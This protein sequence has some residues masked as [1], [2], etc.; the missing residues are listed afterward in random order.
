[1]MAYG[2][3]RVGMAIASDVSRELL[4]MSSFGDAE[5]MIGRYLGMNPRAKGSAVSTDFRAINV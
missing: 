4:R 2:Q 5:E 1:M 3:G